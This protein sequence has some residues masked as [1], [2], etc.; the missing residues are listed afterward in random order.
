MLLSLYHYDV[1]IY[2]APVIEYEN[3]PEIQ[4]VAQT[5]ENGEPSGVTSTSF[6]IAFKIVPEQ[7]V[8]GMVDK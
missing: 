4:P 1:I 7:E 2:I 5:D 8:N 3:I 6:A